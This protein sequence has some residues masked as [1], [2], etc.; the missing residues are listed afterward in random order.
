ML[1]D[2]DLG[3]IATESPEISIKDVLVVVDIAFVVALTTCNTLPVG[4]V[5][6]P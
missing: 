5:T 2:A 3:V 1:F 4:I 6:L